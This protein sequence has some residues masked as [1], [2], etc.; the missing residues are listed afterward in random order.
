M[1][2][3]ALVMGFAGSVHCI[4]MCSP[5]AMA[6]TNMNSKAL[7]NRMVYNAGRIMTYAL[8]GALVSSLGYILPFSKFQNLLSIVLGILLLLAGMGLLKINIPILSRAIGWFTLSI[9]NLFGVFFKKKSLSAVFVLGTLNGLLPCGLIL[10]A[11]SFCITLSTSGEGSLFML[12]FGLGTLPAMLGFT[13]ILPVIVKRFRLN[14][15]NVTRGMLMTSGVL[16]IARV[17][18]V[19]LHHQESIRQGLIDIVLCR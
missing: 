2:V 18:I 13:S 9:R 5:L 7:L 1:I 8:L 14:M 3:A 19:T 10:I 12:F 4:G 17:Y 6:V 15:Y 16:L 11:L